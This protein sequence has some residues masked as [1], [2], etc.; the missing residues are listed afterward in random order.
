MRILTNTLLLASTMFL[1]ACDPTPFRENENPGHPVGIPISENVAPTRVKE[2]MDVSRPEPDSQKREP[3]NAPIFSRKTINGITFEGVSYDSRT[4]RLRVIDQPGG[5]GSRYSSAK[6]LADKTDALLAINAGFFTPEGAPLG[7]VISAGKTSGGWNS[8]SSLGS[9]VYRETSSGQPGIVRRSSRSNVSGSSELLQAGPLLVENGS[10]VPGL[11]TQKVASRSLIF[12]DGGTRWWIG[13]AT[14]CTLSGLANTLSTASP[15]PWEI[16]TALNLDG[17]RS[18]DLFVS[19]KIRGG[20]V[21]RRG[22][23]NRPVRNFF[24]LDRR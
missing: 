8:A 12:S 16:R 5:P 14:P 24:V 9:G 22:F 20:P 13:I 11:E 15:A 23:L 19:G 3:A 2:P 10:A 6:N 21:D 18:T 4:H 1:T 7:L 17:G